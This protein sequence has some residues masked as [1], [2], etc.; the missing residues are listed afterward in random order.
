MCVRVL[1]KDYCPVCVSHFLHCALRRSVGSTGGDG[2]GTLLPT[3]NPDITSTAQTP[4]EREIH[5]QNKRQHI[6]MCFVFGC[7]R[8]L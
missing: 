8:Q 5:V 6:V 1:F 2:H 3:S 4:E 7:G